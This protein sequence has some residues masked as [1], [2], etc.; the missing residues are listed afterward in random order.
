MSLS[1]LFPGFYLFLNGAAY[2]ILAWLFLVEPLAW[3]DRLQ[4]NL[5]DIVGYTELKTMYVG[6]MAALG[7][8]FVVASLIESWRQPAVW[9]AIFSYLG[10]ASVRGWGIFVD[11]VFN[12]LIY[13]LFG[14]EVLDLLAGFLALY[15]LQLAKQKRRNPYY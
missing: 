8:F 7:L 1:R 5:V 13:Q 15:C 4:V 2:C 6:V 9:L 12:E 14:I 11:Q 10:L 3:F